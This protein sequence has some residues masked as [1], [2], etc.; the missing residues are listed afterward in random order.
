MSNWSKAQVKKKVRKTA[1]T[2]RGRKMKPKTPKKPFYTPK[3][4]LRPDRM[5]D[6][7]VQRL[8]YILWI[9]GT[10]EEACTMAGISDTTFDNRY[11]WEYR[12]MW[13][14]K[15]IWFDA[16]GKAE[17]VIEEREALF[18]EIMDYAMAQ[19][20]VRARQS[21][22]KNIVNGKE[23]TLDW[24]I[25]S[26]DIRY[27]K[28]IDIENKGNMIITFGMPPSPHVIP[29]IKTKSWAE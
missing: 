20:F 10:K 16:T 25:S 29:E 14:F 3:K 1:G 2:N 6:L 24:F 19:P 17:E 28:K 12:I 5:T 15:M 13:K 27:S 4:R 26:R 9:D 23:R 18:R 11:K 21:Q 22:Q 8:Q 7:V